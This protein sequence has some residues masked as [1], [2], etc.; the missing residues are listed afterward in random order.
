MITTHE[1]RDKVVEA[2]CKT[3]LEFY[4]PDP[5]KS[6]DVSRMINERHTRRVADLLD[7]RTIKVAIGGDVDVAAKYMSPTI[8]TATPASKVMQDEIF[9]P[10]LPVISVDSMEAAIDFVNDRDKPLGL[11]V[12]SSNRAF[13]DAVLAQTSSGGVCVNDCIMH[14]AN[15]E[16][17][18]GGVGPSGCGAYHGKHGFD[19]FSHK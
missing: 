16:L 7:D 12:F 14:A 15:P 1:H 2:L 17:P 9:G 3:V 5:K 8:V 18:F 11:Y 13:K 4:G 6:P 19:A 10:I